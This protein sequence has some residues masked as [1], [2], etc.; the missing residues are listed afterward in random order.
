MALPYSLALVDADTVFDPE[1]HA[2]EDFTVI[3][4]EVS[5]EEEE[6]ALLEI[7]VENPRVGLLAPGRKQWAF[8]AWKDPR[9]QTA[10]PIVLF[11]GRVVSIAENMQDNRI[12]LNC[13]ARPSDFEDL[14]A[15]LAD[16]MR[17][18]FY[19]GI[20]FDEDYRAN[21]DSVLDA[22][23]Q[24]WDIDRVTL[25]VSV[26]DKIGSA[27]DAVTLDGNS[28]ISLTMTYGEIPPSAVTINA[29]VFWTQK[30][31]GIVDLN[32]KLI[33]ASRAA[34]GDAHLVST[35]TG[36]G[37]ASRWPKQGTNIG[38]DWEY[39]EVSIYPADGISVQ[40]VVTET[41]VRG[42]VVEARATVIG[43]RKWRFDTV[44]KVLYDTER[45]Y[46]EKI[47]LTVRAG[48]QAV[49][50][51]P[52]DSDHLIISLGSG[53]VAAEID[54]VDTHMEMPIRDIR[55]NA[56]FPTDRGRRWVE[57]FGIPLAVKEL[58]VRAR[59]VFITA[60]IPFS[61]AIELNCRKSAVITDDRL[62]GGEAIGKIT[63]YRFGLRDEREFGEV[64]IACCIGTGEPVVEVPGEPT[65][66][67]E[68]YVEPGYQQ[69]EGGTTAVNG[70]VTYGEYA[71]PPND[72]GV[73][74]F[75]MTPDTVLESLIFH[76]GVN[77]QKAVIQGSHRTKEAVADALNAVYSEVRL[78]LVPLNTGPFETTYT[79]PVSDLSIPKQIDLG[80]P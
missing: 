39:N 3:N 35:Y 76:N 44:Y 16:S 42:D 51:E 27:E 46:K 1:L 21:S 77:V 19:D 72:D 17:S 18:S 30:A 63:G 24:G 9:A 50:T 65:Y 11:F 13:R 33:E 26:T 2:T 15:A 70:E 71:V 31:M 52:G 34:G 78:N 32:A 22:R 67:E 20:H 49:V 6:F 61:D 79:V 4:F 75:Q 38:G 48:I 41:T 12:S 43:F 10:E 80:A 56:F 58:K 8:V 47:S 14:K 66:V 62:P 7:E 53:D 69:Y 37:L 45:Q 28:I 55:R 60:G 40:E 57:Q 68:G 36:Q 23:P 59:C 29:E 73:N 54:P 64:T 74:L 5:Q 25:D